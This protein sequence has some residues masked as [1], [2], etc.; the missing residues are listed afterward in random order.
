M[1]E[2]ILRLINKFMS[3]H[4]NFPPWLEIA[5][6]QLGVAEIPGL[7]HNDAI[8]TY[9]KSTKLKAT[10][11][12]V[13]WCSSYVNWVLKKAGIQGTDSAAARSWLDWGVP[14]S[15]PKIGAVTV[16]SRGKNPALG[17]VGF[18][19]GFTESGK[20]SLLGGNQ[21]DSVSIQEFPKTKVISYRWPDV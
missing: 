3:R 4:D 13:P 11:D 2:I 21:G 8:L 10:E 14:L 20:V 17:H 18:F 12:E 6:S 19:M 5:E 15:E 9:H 7:T 16:L 1:W